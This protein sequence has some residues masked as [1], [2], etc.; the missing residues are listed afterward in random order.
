MNALRQN[1]RQLRLDL[2]DHHGLAVEERIINDQEGRPV[3][4]LDSGGSQRPVLFVHGGGSDASEWPE[5]AAKLQATGRRVVLADRPGHGLSY[6]IDYTGV[7]FR[8]AAADWGEDV[9]TSIHS[10]PVDIVANSMGGFFSLSTALRRPDLINRLVLIGAPAGIDKWIPYPLRM[11]GFKPINRL[12][13]AKSA[14]WDVD[15][16]R[17]LY[18][19]ILVEYPEK[20]L[21]ER[22]ELMVA[23]G[24]LPAYKVGWRTLLESCVSL[25][26]FNYMIRDEVA[27]LN[28]PV[29]MIWGD[30]DAF[31]PPSSGQALAAR[32]QDA[33]IE[34]VE[35]A[36]H[37]PWVDQIDRCTALVLSAL[38]GAGA[39][40]SAA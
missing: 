33:S 40:S 38:E 3:Y 6:P 21:T 1:V 35:D 22:L 34:V 13:F 20:V 14:N 26:G 27:S 12:L 31:A 36:G 24:K 25:T 2:C 7:D 17:K 10:G 5:L 8:A 16:Y 11:L 9:M 30:A 39:E 15:D 18:E 32:M 23:I 37:L 28:V 4:T 29:R 19:E